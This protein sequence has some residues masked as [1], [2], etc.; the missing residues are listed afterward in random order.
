MSIETE[1]ECAGKTAADGLRITIEKLTYLP[2][3]KTA[4][5][6]PEYI[7]A[8]HGLSKQAAR[9]L[10]RLGASPWFSATSAFSLVRFCCGQ[11]HKCGQPLQSRSFGNA[12][13]LLF[14]TRKGIRWESDTF[15]VLY[16][17]RYPIPNGFG[18]VGQITLKM[19]EYRTTS[20]VRF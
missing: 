20:L 16:Q 4:G 8:L 7:H 3:K 19:G 5:S 11:G 2:P 6:H 12:G 14:Y 18:N 9:A 13:H 10:V 1:A 15:A 17:E